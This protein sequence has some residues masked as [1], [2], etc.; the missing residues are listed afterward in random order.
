L[1]TRAIVEK[2]PEYCTASDADCVISRVLATS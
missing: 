2:T 1:S